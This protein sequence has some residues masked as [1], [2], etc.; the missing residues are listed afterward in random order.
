VTF[1]SLYGATKMK[2]TALGSAGPLISWD[3]DVANNTSNSVFLPG[4][5]TMVT[6]EGTLEDADTEPQA[7]VVM[8]AKP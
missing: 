7:A 1:G 3:R 2:I 6:V 4:E 5:T 8:H